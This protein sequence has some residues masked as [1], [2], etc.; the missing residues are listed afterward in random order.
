MNWIVKTATSQNFALSAT[1]P[2]HLSCHSADVAASARCRNAHSIV[3]ATRSAFSTSSL[4]STGALP[5][6]LAVWAFASFALLLAGPEHYPRLH[7]LL[8]VQN[9]VLTGVLSLF[10]WDVGNRLGQSFQQWIAWVFCITCL[11]E[12]LHLA[13]SA[14]GLDPL[15]APDVYG[16]WLPSATWLASATV[17]AGGVAAA[18]LLLRR[19][20]GLQN[21]A[22]V[23]ALVAIS[24]LLLAFLTVVPDPGEP[25]WLEGSFPCLAFAPI[26]WAAIGVVGWQ[27]REASR[28]LP[29]F[30][31]M[32]VLLLLANIAM[33]FSRVPDDIPALLAHLGKSAGFWV[34]LISKMHLASGDMLERQRAEKKFRGLLESAPDRIVVVNAAGRILLANDQAE[35]MF[36]YR[37]EDL[38]DREIEVLMPERFR[39]AHYIHVSQF[40]A[41]PRPRPMGRGLE[42][43]GLRRDGTEF[44]LEIS[45]S[46][47]ETP[48]GLLVSAAIRDLTREKSI[49]S[50]IR[51]LNHSLEQRAEDL[52][53]ANKELEAFTYTAAHDLRAPLRHL[54]GYATFLKELCYERLDD[55][56]RHFLDR[57]IYSARHMATLL[58]ELLNFSRLGRVEMQRRDV[59]LPQLIARIR[60]ELQQ[61]ANGVRVQWEV[62]ELPLVEG[63]QALLH[64]ALFNLLSNAV[65][66][67]SKKS[68][69]VIAVGGEQDL[70]TGMFTLFVRDN[71]AGFDMQY[72]GKLFQVFQRLHRSRDFDGTGIGLAIV[73][74]I[75]ERHGGRVWAE[76]TL[77]EG[78]TFYCSLPLWRQENGYA[79]V[80][81]AGR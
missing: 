70:A 50:E 72:A 63:D 76:G 40:C 52:M 41:A 43:Q 61:D 23:L 24:L 66:Y 46:P 9:I 31:V 54:D 6:T 59:S 18:L 11:L 80:H 45:L 47:V 12:S 79:R 69:P 17:L 74:R 28:T 51:M 55:E 20:S 49:Q 15:F 1:R 44:P 27:W 19:N 48:E 39:L 58:D 26:L 38:I 36:G 42:L 78:A 57:I 16:T 25:G 35:R 4:L 29:T 34:M 30:V 32:S 67:S 5:G 13:A 75:V 2:P 56:A 37:R 60:E 73:R 81:S 33:L 8:D 7:P 3:A 71:G 22:F 14:E 65:K 62:A 68:Q 64:Q 21:Y 10:F 77:G 53:A